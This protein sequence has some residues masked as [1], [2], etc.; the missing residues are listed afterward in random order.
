MG[1][2]AIARTGVR[3]CRDGAV[4]F[5]PRALITRSLTTR[6]PGAVWFAAASCAVLALVPASPALSQSG[7]TLRVENE[8]RECLYS[9]TRPGRYRHDDR[10]SDFALLGECRKEWV[11]Y[12]DVCTK[13]GVDT[14]TCVMKSRLVIHA[15]LDLTGK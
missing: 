11:A 8:Y 14:R 1:I 9:R 12:M 4:L 10:E 13:Q 6:S 15:I 2:V 3:G 7:D 5:H